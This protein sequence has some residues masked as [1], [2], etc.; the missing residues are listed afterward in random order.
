MFSVCTVT[1]GSKQTKLRNN[2]QESSIS[3]GKNTR[4]VLVSCSVWKCVFT[5]ISSD[6]DPSEVPGCHMLQPVSSQRSQ[7]LFQGLVS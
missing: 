6:V 2:K 7:K 1:P 5:A 4:V 3:T